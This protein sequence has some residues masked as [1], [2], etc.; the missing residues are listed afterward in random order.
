M[1]IRYAIT[2]CLTLEDAIKVRKT[3]VVDADERHESYRI[4][5]ADTL[6]N[7]YYALVSELQR[8]KA[9]SAARSTEFNGALETA[10]RA[11]HIKLILDLAD[12]GS[13]TNKQLMELLYN[14]VGTG[15]Q[16]TASLVKKAFPEVSNMYSAILALEEFLKTP[17]P[18][19]P[20]ASLIQAKGKRAAKWKRYTEEDAKEEARQ[21]TLYR[22]REAEEKAKLTK[23]V[24][25]A[26]R[27]GG[28]VNKND[29][30]ITL[31]Y[32]DAKKLHDVLSDFSYPE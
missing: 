3:I 7:A 6:E 11:R 2:K 20:G 31:E 24:Q 19:V 10:L 14:K 12:R 8:L 30:T 22:E 25:F 9:N 13:K 29:L 32:E 27:L 5:E 17:R 21:E 18:L 1:A 23:L 28:R 4:V 26:A 15:A 16:T